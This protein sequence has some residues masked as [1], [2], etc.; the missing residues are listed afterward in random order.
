MK[1]DRSSLW[2]VGTEGLLDELK[3]P[4]LASNPADRLR[5]RTAETCPSLLFRGMVCRLRSIILE[6]VRLAGLH[7]FDSDRN[8]TERNGNPALLVLSRSGIGYRD[9]FGQ[10][11]FGRND[12][13]PLPADQST[14]LDG[15]QHDFALNWCN[16]F[17]QEHDPKAALGDFLK[18]A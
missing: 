6:G 8:L 7:R 18:S 5:A 10:I 16:L 13:H 17:G 3:H 2:S 4:E 15:L 9:C 11:L 14:R 12:L 1:S